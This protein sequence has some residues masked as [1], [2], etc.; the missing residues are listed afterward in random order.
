LPD[1]DQQPVV[2]AERGELCRGGAEHRQFECVLQ[3]RDHRRHIRHGKADL[4]DA[5]QLGAGELARR[6]H[7]RQVV[8]CDQFEKNPI[9]PVN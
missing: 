4:T 3:S 8:S 2:I 7:R 1:Q 6:R 9:Q 5:H